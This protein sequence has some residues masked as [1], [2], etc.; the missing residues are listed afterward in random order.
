MWTFWFEENKQK[1]AEG[2]Y[3][4]GWRDGNWTFWHSNGQKYLE[5]TYTDGRGS[6]WTAW[7]EDGQPWFGRIYT[8]LPELPYIP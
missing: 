3:K 8:D 2:A 6:G 7:T 4:D 1:W 5:G